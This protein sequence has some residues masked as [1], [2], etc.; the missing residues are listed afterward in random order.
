[1]KFFFGLLL[2]LATQCA[3]AQENTVFRFKVDANELKD[4]KN[5]GLRGS[6]PPLSWDQTFPLADADQ[7]GV[8]E[9]SVSF[10]NPAT[11]MLEYKFVYGDQKITYELPEGNRILIL[12]G[13]RELPLFKW[14]VN[15]PV[16]FRE[17]PLLSAEQV[18]ADYAIA[19]DALLQ[20][21][22]GLYRYHSKMQMDSIFQHFEKV[23]TQP[24]SY[25][26]AF[27][28]FTEMTA[29]IKCGHTYPNFYNQSGFIKQVVLNQPE[30]LPFAFRVVDR[31]MII[32]A[33][34]SQNTE[35][36]KGTEVLAIDD[37]P[38]TEIFDALIHLV[39]ADGSSNNKRFADLNTFGSD[40]YE[41][42][43]AYYPLLFPVSNKN[44][45]LKI[46]TSEQQVAKTVE[47]EAISRM[48]RMAVLKQRDPN[49]SGSAD[50]LWKLEFN[51]DNTAYL[52]LGTFDVFG[53]SFNWEDFL[54][55]AFDEIN[56]R[57][58]ANL[59]LDI[60]WNE[61][62]Q[63]EVLLM[64]ARY[65]TVKPIKTES[66]ERLIRY[67]TIP[68]SL[69]PYLSTWDNSFFDVSNRVVPY[70][71]DYFKFKSGDD[72]QIKPFKKAFTGNVYLLVNA[73]NSSATFYFAEIVKENKLAT[74]VGEATGGNQR[75]LNGGLM[76][77]LRLPNSGIE[78]DI[79]VI[80]TFA[81]GRPDAGV[82]PDYEIK[83]TV[84]SIIAGKDP[85]RE[86]TEKM[87]SEK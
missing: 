84:E 83:E 17:V 80:G 15:T 48:E 36:K 37:R 79:P 7:D 23:F 69:K 70:D 3:C 57:K 31:R 1:M 13:S 10:S 50:D 18:A 62:G 72:F 85:A 11:G 86:F 49:F 20:L 38:V 63:D 28:H 12:N 32:T 29:S 59:I 45:R 76:F 74:L 44:F 75:G 9:G 21:H 42:F 47:V 22:P 66:R 55:N 52:Q 40:A 64:L 67:Q 54:M 82:T 51:A 53:L 65:M 68:P 24:M 30:H 56:R 27:L 5:F 78:I 6:L 46:A 33:N 34:A 87:I 2:L 81:A 77:F 43:D 35:L 25:K 14:N 19:K 39:K 61:G 26:E 71:E 58:A 16:D 4:P 60:R 73:A 41:M 8:Y